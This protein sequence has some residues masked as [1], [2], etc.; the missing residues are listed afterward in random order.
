LGHD[1]EMLVF[2]DRGYPLIVFPTSR[3][4]YYEAKDFLLVES[5]REAV[6]QQKI[7][8][9]CLDSV[10]EH[11]WY[12]K[13]LHPAARV[14]NHVRYDQMV[15]RELVPTLQREC[16]VDKVAVAGCS[17][18]GFQA[19]NFAFRHP[20]QVAYLL[21][22]GAAFDMRQFLD[23]HY[24][25]N[26]Y[27]NNPPD[28]LPDAPT[29]HLHPMKI[30]LGTA[31]DDFCKPGNYQISDMLHRK[32]VDHW[33]DVRPGTHDWPVWRDMFAHYVSLM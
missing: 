2:G 11:S 1:V 13:H 21:S 3:G 19:L 32:G 8:L 31:E 24:D 29:E 17:F 5:V 4:R 23:G 26:V 6:E 27:F 7:K 9:Y 18:G 20:E 25:E 16:H 30:V 28:Y 14:A 33:L 10:D 15:S 12:A 22:M